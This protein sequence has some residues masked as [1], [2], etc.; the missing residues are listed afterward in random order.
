MNPLCFFLLANCLPTFCGCSKQE[1]LVLLSVSTLQPLLPALAHRAC[2]VN[3]L[4]G[5]DVSTFADSDDLK[6]QIL[7]SV[8]RSNHSPTSVSVSC[9]L[10]VWFSG[11]SASIDSPSKHVCLQ[12]QRVRLHF[13]MFVS[14]CVCFLLFSSV[15]SVE[16]TNPADLSLQN[17]SP[18]MLYSPLSP[19]HTCRS[20]LQN[21]L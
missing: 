2:C 12:C 10:F 6:W 16:F 15:S 18:F 20:S 3:M 13:S 7:V 21:K 9:L 19:S 8:T 1:R 14:L 4:C 11:I 5:S 17:N